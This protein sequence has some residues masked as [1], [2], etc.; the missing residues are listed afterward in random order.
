M[1]YGSRVDD[2]IERIRYCERLLAA[3]D[4]VLEDLDDYITPDSTDPWKATHDHLKQ[5]RADV[6]KVIGEENEIIAAIRAQCSHALE[7][8]GEARPPLKH[9][10][11]CGQAEA[12]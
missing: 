6:V 4:L 1:S 8:I 2:A 3:Y 12:E 9:C 5:V 7:R 10:V 11:R